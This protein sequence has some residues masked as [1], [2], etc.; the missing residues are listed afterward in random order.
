MVAQPPLRVTLHTIL[1]GTHKLYIYHRHPLPE[2]EL[3]HL[4]HIIATMD[5]KVATP[6]IFDKIF[7]IDDQPQELP[8]SDLQ[9]IGKVFQRY[10]ASMGYGISL[11]HR[12][13]DL[14][15]GHV[16]AH[17][18]RL[19]GAID[20]CEPTSLASLGQEESTVP[21]AYFLNDENKFQP[22][23]YQIQEYDPSP[24]TLPPSNF[25]NDLRDVL[26]A[27]RLERTLC[28][29]LNEGVAEGMLGFE[30][31]LV[32]R[33]GT[34]TELVRESEISPELLASSTTTAWVFDD[35]LDGEGDFRVRIVR[36]CR[37][38]PHE[39]HMVVG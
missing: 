2:T 20:E 26:L 25:I 29:S 28:L 11:L 9:A 15:L 34:R 36:K 39:R 14:P 10:K 38:L 8:I 12:H 4:H 16:M 6:D 27:R 37:R 31:M 23:E 3:T 19:N 5:H 18:S 17:R 35:V 7:L 1:R 22:F 32:D 21:C 33:A 24:F 30:T 13:C